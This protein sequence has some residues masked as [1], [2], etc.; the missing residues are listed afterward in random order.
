M[1]L[2]CSMGMHEWTGCKCSKCG[3]SRDEGHDWA[4][5]CEKCAK[6]GKT[7]TGAHS[8]TGCKC[9]KCGKSRDEGH[10][11]ATDCEKCAKCGKTRTG[12]HSWTGCKCSKCE[13]KASAAVST[14]LLHRAAK[15]REIKSLAEL[16]A[17]GVDFN[18]KD[19]DGLTILVKAAMDGDAETLTWLLDQGLDVRGGVDGTTAL[20]LAANRGHANTVSLLL[21][22]GADKDGR[23]SSQKMTPLILAA[24]AGR[25]EVVRLLISAGADK[26]VRDSSGMAAIHRAV[27]EGQ[28]EAV[29]TLIEAGVEPDTMGEEKYQARPL[30]YAALKH[31]A[32]LAHYLVQSGA[33]ADLKDALGNTPLMIAQRHGDND[34]IKALTGAYIPP[35]SPQLQPTP[36]KRKTLI[37]RESHDDPSAIMMAAHNGQTET[38]RQLIANGVGITF[39]D[40][41]LVE[42]AIAGHLETA[43]L[44]IEAGA[45]V[46]ANVTVNDKGLITTALMAAAQNGKTDCVRMLIEKG[47]N[48]NARENRIGLTALML[49]AARGNAETVRLLVEKGANVDARTGDGE[50]AISIAASSGHRELVNALKRV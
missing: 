4:T 42:A 43:Q 20:H 46:N 50:T 26:P 33:H 44:L 18:A 16:Y 29:K 38:V 3:K 47:A 37:T 21:A 48:I 2:K 14:E 49:A 10:D 31:H 40:A 39:M 24:A 15:A 5:D 11:W 19:K 7:R 23:E 6:C 41:A 27:G 1:N 34:V 9:S 36:P 45:D 8:W 28:L 12:A 25:A 17:A 13:I 22:K 30:H 35:A 32:A